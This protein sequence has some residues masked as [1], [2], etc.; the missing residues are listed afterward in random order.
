MNS[1]EVKK[2]WR[3]NKGEINRPLV[4]FYPYRQTNGHAC[5]GPVCV[6]MDA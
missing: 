6:W 5:M 3:K 4:S 2:I 1:L